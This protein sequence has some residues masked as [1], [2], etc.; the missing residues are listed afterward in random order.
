MIN[1]IGIFYWRPNFK[2]GFLYFEKLTILLPLTRL[3]SLV[4]NIS[5]HLSYLQSSFLNFT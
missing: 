2:Y 1:L 3:Q 5:I 4:L